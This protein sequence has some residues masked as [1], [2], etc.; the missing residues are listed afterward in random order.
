MAITKESMRSFHNL[1][2][3][4]QP[5]GIHYTK[6][7]CKF[8]TGSTPKLLNVYVRF[9]FRNVTVLARGVSKVTG[10]ILQSSQSKGHNPYVILVVKFVINVWWLIMA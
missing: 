1:D 10:E 5:R 3:L 9:S 8:T 6:L 4:Y 2:K 7:K